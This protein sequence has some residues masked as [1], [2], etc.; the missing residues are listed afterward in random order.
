VKTT[1]LCR[2][3]KK[4]KINVKRALITHGV[5]QGNSLEYFRSSNFTTEEKT[6]VSEWGQTVGVDSGAKQ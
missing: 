3:D 4:S 5:D 6:D 1:C 2:G